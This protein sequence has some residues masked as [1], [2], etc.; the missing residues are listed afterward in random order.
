VLP[1]IG[2]IEG[3]PAGR[4]YKDRAMFPEEERLARPAQGA[5]S[6]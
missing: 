4:P 5:R 6:A 2:G 3:R 1:Q